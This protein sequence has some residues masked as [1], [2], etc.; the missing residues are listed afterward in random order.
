[1]A[2]K[3]TPTKA[4]TMLRENRA[5]GKPLTPRQKGLFGLVAG[6]KKPTRVKK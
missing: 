2:K 4:K 1:M 5:Q 6:G 3:L